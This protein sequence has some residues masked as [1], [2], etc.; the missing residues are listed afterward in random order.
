MGSSMAGGL[1]EVRGGG[2]SIKNI[3]INIQKLHD[4][5]ITISTAT[6]GMGTAQVRAELERMLLSVVNDVNY[7]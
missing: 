7:Q 4:G 1:S 6:L 5:G 2:G 3:T